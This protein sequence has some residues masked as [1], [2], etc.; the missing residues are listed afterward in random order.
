MKSRRRTR[1]KIKKKK[2]KNKKNICDSTM[3]QNQ[4]REQRKTTNRSMGYGKDYSI[5][6]R[7]REMEWYRVSTVQEM[8]FQYKDESIYNHHT[9]TSF[10]R[11]PDDPPSRK[12]MFDDTELQTQKTLKTLST[13][14]DPYSTIIKLIQ[15]SEDRQISFCRQEFT[16]I[17][18]EMKVEDT[19]AR[20]S[21]EAKSGKIKQTYGKFYEEDRDGLSILCDQVEAIG[22]EKSGPQ[23]DAVGDSKME[24]S[25]AQADVTVNSDGVLPDG[26]AQPD[27]MVKVDGVLQESDDVDNQTSLDEIEMKEINDC[28]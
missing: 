14:A 5:D 7:R 28:V 1:R 3:Q 13:I 6:R 25:D 16:K 10:E 11:S 12:K 27:A 4:P 2:N 23:A 15:E 8:G 18:D 17:K 9:T 26:D 21:S 24:E 20:K 19:P 22:M